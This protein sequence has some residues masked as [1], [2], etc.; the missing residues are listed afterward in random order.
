MRDV[1]STRA[2][3]GRSRK[4]PGILAVVTFALG[5]GLACT[6]FAVLDAMFFRILPVPEPDRLVS[7]SGAA[8]PPGGD[9]LDWWGQ[10]RSLSALA[11]FSTGGASLS[12]S[13]GDPDR[14]SAA[15][16]SK[17]FF[18]VLRVTPLVCRVLSTQDEP[19]GAVRT[20][21]VPDHV[22]ALRLSVR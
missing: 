20:L 1:S 9:A 5:T 10:S 19:P 18:S 22:S 21:V 17:D 3:A 7:I 2:F 11:A 14:C 4:L 15:V 16:V 12:T 8:A 6:V 13:E